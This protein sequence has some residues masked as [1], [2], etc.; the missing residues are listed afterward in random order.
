MA[1]QR[2]HGDALDFVGA[3][4]KKLFRGRGDGDVIALDFDLRDAVHLHRHAFADIDFRRLH[5]NGENFQR[6]DV[7]L[8][9]DRP[10]E[11]PAALDDAEADFA[12]GAVGIKDLA[13][14][15]GNDEHLIG[16]DLRVA[17]GPDAGKDEEHE[18]HR[19]NA[20]HNF[21]SVGYFS[22]HGNELHLLSPVFLVWLINDFDEKLRP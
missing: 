22:E 10:H 17:A 1:F 12:R 21:E 5:I 9:I 8:F 3:L 4:A 18:Q 16:A 11:A 14:A 19:D 7:H 15:P 6:Q 20:A 13:L 2:L